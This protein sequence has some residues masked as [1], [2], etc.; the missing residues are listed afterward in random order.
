MNEINLENIKNIKFGFCI[1]IFANPGMLFFR[2]PAY[3]KLDWHSIRDTIIRC[4]EL[5]YDSLFVADH[6]TLGND[7]EIWECLSTMAALLAITKKMEVF[8]I[9]LCNNFRSPGVVAKTFA[10][11]SHISEGRVGLF[12]DYGWRRA[13]F[14]AYGINFGESSEDRIKQMDEGLTVITGLLEEDNFSYD[15]NYYK[16]K[17]AICNPKPVRRI[18]IWM[19]EA[20]N[21][22]M[23]SS[24]VK[25]ADV[26]NSMPCSPES[27]Q[28]KIDI[29][30][31]ECEKQGRDF[32]N[33]GLSLETQILIRRTNE[34]IEEDLN[35]YSKLIIKN[36]SF[37]DD[38][39][40]QLE[41]T[42]PNSADFNKPENLKKK[43]IIGTPV[44]VKGKLDQYI[45]KG[46]D[47]FMLWFMDY[48]DNHGIDLFA[49][50]VLLYY[51]KY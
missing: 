4:E 16:I 32:A 1:P 26:F 15:G 30:K 39:P 5:G 33:I 46:V 36:N 24:I 49:K 38:I 47:H 6:L 50:E 44:E 25:H 3:K 14:D 17:N 48:P 10:T 7:G 18:P 28:D 34:E 41:A 45:A 40:S 20:D 13:E 51:K 11:M 35:D 23:V 31:E 27:F 43:F 8:P 42:T 9:H 12:Y 2:T 37:D 21:P 19:G 22:Y 29:I